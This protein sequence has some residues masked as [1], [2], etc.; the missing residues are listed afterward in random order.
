MYSL[1]E[2]QGSLTSC[3]PWQLWGVGHDLSTEQ[4]QKFTLQY[5]ERL[6]LDSLDPVKEHSLHLCHWGMI[7]GAAPIRGAGEPVMGQAEADPPFA[8]HCS[9][10]CFWSRHAW[11]EL[12]EID[13]GLLTSCVKRSGFPGGSVVKN[14]PVNAG[15]ADS[16]P[17]SGRSPGE[18]N[19]N[20]LQ[21]TCL[22]NSMK[23]EAW[24]ATVSLA[25]Q[26]VRN[27]LATK[28]EQFV[29][30]QYTLL[31]QDFLR[32]KDFCSIKGKK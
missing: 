19:D 23:R 32:K 15:D 7:W 14:L 6:R 30:K 28:Q 11:L 24:Q 31:Y 26:R 2:G 22:E 29:Y 8:N 4:Q 10:T 21:D 3:S 13:T 17:V 18:G 5:W 20:P 16:I 27:N 25:S 9:S 12:S 1:G